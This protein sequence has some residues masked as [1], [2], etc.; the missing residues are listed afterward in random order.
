MKAETLLSGGIYFALFLMLLFILAY[1]IVVPG[2]ENAK[3]ANIAKGQFM[4]MYSYV[5][6]M[7]C[8]WQVNEKSYC[9]ILKFIARLRDMKYKNPEMMDVLERQ[10]LKKYK[11]ISD[12]ILSEDEFE[13]D[14][15]L[16]K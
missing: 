13:V 4:T 8:D 9:A 2:T 10:F 11:G 16:R 6:M 14:Q 5:Q 12:Q 7:I 3:K 1:W 15:V